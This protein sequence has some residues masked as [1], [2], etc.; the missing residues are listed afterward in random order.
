MLPLCL[1]CRSPEHLKKKSKPAAIDTT[2]LEFEISKS[3][4]KV[5]ENIGVQ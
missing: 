2:E 4:K 1:S 5:G 3:N